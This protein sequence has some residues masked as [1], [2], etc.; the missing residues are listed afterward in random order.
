MVDIREFYGDPGDEKP[1]RK[2]V[3]LN[4][5]Q[6]SIYIFPLPSSNLTWRYDAV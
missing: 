2:G 6:A 5:D 4:L 3:S 1:G